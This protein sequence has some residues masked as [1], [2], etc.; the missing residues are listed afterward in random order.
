MQTPELE[1]LRCAGY[2][3]SQAA[4][5]LS[6]EASAQFR[7]TL[8]PLTAGTARIG[9]TFLES[10][11]PQIEGGQRIAIEGR[12]L[13]I[14]SVGG[15]TFGRTIGGAAVSALALIGAFLF[16]RGK[17][18]RNAQIEFQPA[19]SPL[20]SVRERL[21]DLDRLLAEEGGSAF[22]D[23]LRDLLMDALK[24]GGVTDKAVSAGEFS[25]WLSQQDSETRL[26]YGPAL[27][28][29]EQV[30]RVRF[31]GWTPRPEEN[32]AA[33]KELES[34]LVHIE[35]TMIYSAKEHI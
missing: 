3:A 27:A 28:L 18:R 8:I 20:A 15:M 13:Q 21:P 19:I 6:N 2:S 9:T 25:Q 12:S 35:E 16:V 5:S 29:M 24:L 10:N 23:R 31:A 22:Y 34:V 32:R 7:F 1:N 14:G 33:R 17:R 4:S 30:E 26:K 11:L